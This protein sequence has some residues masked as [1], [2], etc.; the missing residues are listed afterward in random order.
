[1][2]VLNVF[3]FVVNFFEVLLRLK[4]KNQKPSEQDEQHPRGGFGAR[5][6]AVLL[7]LASGCEGAKPR[8]D[9]AGD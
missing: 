4:V 9:S 6:S 2:R 8:G 3:E 1:M 5:V 7:V